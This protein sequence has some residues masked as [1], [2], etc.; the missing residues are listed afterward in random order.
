MRK[1]IKIFSYLAVFLCEI[2]SAYTQPNPIPGQYPAVSSINFIRVWEPVK[3]YTSEA[4]IISTSRVVKEVRQST[5]YFDGLGRPLQTVIKSGSLQTGQ[6]PTDMVAPVVYDAFGREQYKYLPYAS[7]DNTGTFKTNPFNDQVGFYNTQLSGQGGETNVGAN[8][9]NWAYSKTNFEASPLN[10]VEETYAPGVNWVGSEGAANPNDRH[11]VKMKYW[12]NTAADAVRIWNV[13]DVTNGFGTYASTATYPA[14]ELYKN[15]S[16]DERGKQVIEFKDKEGQVILKRVQ[17]TGITDDGTGNTPSGDGGGWLC[18]YYM[19]DDL[20]RLR[21]VIQPKGVELITSNWLLTDAT[22]LAEQCFRYEY[23]G[24]GRMIMKKVPGAGEVYMVYDARDRLVM[25]QDANMRTT[26]K[27]MVTKYDALNRPYETGLWQDNS[28]TTFA[29]HLSAANTSTN[30]P[31]TASNFEQLSITHYDDYANIPAGLSATY[32]TNWNSY[33]EATNNTNFPYQQMPTQ[34]NAVRGMVTWTQVKVLNSSPAKY[35][36][37]VSIYDDKGRVIQLQS[38]NEY[39]NA[40]DA[41]T[42]QYTW[43]GQPYITIQKH[44]LTGSNAQT[45]VLVTKINYDD[46]GRVKDIEKKQSHTQYNGNAMSTAKTV[47]VNEYDKLGQLKNKKLAPYYS[48]GAIEQLTYDYNIRGWMLGMNRN[49]IKDVGTNWFGFELAYD[50]TAN[51]IAGQSYAA[52]QFN[53]NITGT[54]WKTA[55]DLEKRKYDFTYDAVNRLTGADFN[56][57]NSNT[58]NKNAGID[59]SVNNLSYDANGNI[60]TMNQKGWKITG[61]N[62][63][64]QMTYSYFTNSNKLKAVTDAVTAD[65][66]LGDFTDKNTTATDYGYDKNGN[67]VTDLN[68]QM[69]TATG[70]DLTTGGAITYNHLNLP[71]TITVTDKGTIT[72]TYDAAGNK[73]EKKTEETGLSFTVNGTNYTNVKQ[74][75]IT[76]YIGGFVYESKQYD[77]STVNTGLGYVNKLQFTGHEE[78]RI[79][80]IYLPYTATPHVITGFAYDYMLKDHLGNVRMVLTDE[81]KQD[82]YP[83]ATL[84][85]ATHNNGTAISVE[86]QYFSVNA[87][88]VVSKSTATGIPDYQNNNGN[89]PW[90]TLNQHSNNGANS[91]RLYLLNATTNTNENK[92]GLGFIIKVMSG[93]KYSIFGKSY[94]KMPSGGYSGTTNNIIVSEL[95]NAFAGSSVVSSK[96]V[97]GAQ[98]TGQP[99]F[100][101]TMDGLVGTQPGQNSNRPKAAINWILFDDQFKFVSGGFDMVGDAGGSTAGTLKS[102]ALYNLPVNKNGYLYVYVSNESKVNVFFDNLQVVHD[103]GPIVEETHYYPFGLT[104][105]GISSKAMN[106]TPNRLKYNG[107]EEQRQEF[108]DGTGLEWL[109]YGARMYDNQIGRFFQIDPLSE[110][111]PDFSLYVYAINNPIRYIDF[112]GLGPGDRVKKAES[113][114]GKPYKQQYEWSGTTRTFLRTGD[115][116]EA[117]E[118]LDCSELVCRVLFDDRITSEVKS[119]ATGELINFLSN[120]DKFERSDIP[121]VGDIFLWRKGKSGHTGI[122]TKVEGDDV[123]TA[124]AHSTKKGVVKD[125]K[126]K[127]TEFTNHAGWKGFYR[128]K[129]ENNGKNS[130]HKG[131]TQNFLTNAPDF[132]VEYFEKRLMD[133]FKERAIMREAE[134]AIE[135]TKE[136]LKRELKKN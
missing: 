24:R 33:L 118:F 97:T 99:G 39:T 13:T 1:L 104:M 93:D 80:A 37:T 56:Q 22:I 40:L 31:S 98:I 91:D 88:N 124:E 21:C 43:A 136:L 77:N 125:F 51:I 135:R 63:I 30:Y 117:L 50:K 29:S 95:I 115:S 10:R 112:L 103:K 126:R 65:N 111:Y 106:I 108:S 61:S 66:K 15:V 101:S 92:N 110:E 128:P 130:K 25:T 34:S 133:E 132:I 105:S 7:T 67:L 86:Q 4:D 76:T 78:G 62:F 23:D 129:T 42:T 6:T 20:N 70:I 38:K 8:N 72:Y 57:Y 19:Y 36:Y 114:A 17:L 131:T 113:Y 27:W 3:P 32:L 60:L 59:F 116:D 26:N 54:T 18:T 28:D 119:M 75:T 127:V 64:D 44:E 73:L 9:L 134:R 46:L 107:K 69:G 48:E 5:Q 94:H 41:V 102:H 47:T 55:G 79:R 16:I 120:E 58:F 2:N 96:G 90:N 12:I 14:G 122:V 89:P 83:A 49:Y 35:I 53:G 109:D 85:N 100:P 74:T 68:K 82:P 52:Q 123:Y 11:P 81:I 45:T 121:K 87:A 71:Q 84:E